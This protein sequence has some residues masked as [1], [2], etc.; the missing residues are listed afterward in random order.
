M[1]LYYLILG[2]I[3]ILGFG[4]IQG[5][6]INT[7]ERKAINEDSKAQ[8]ELAAHYYKIDNN[9]E[10]SKKALRWFN[11]AAQNGESAAQHH[12]GLM[13]YDGR[14]TT[15]N[16][17]EAYKWFLIAASNNQF[18]AKKWAN[19]TEPHL[20]SEQI[21]NVQKIARNWPKSPDT[22]N[23][24][25]DF[26]NINRIKLNPKEIYENSSKAVV[27]IKSFDKEDKPIATRNIMR[28]KICSFSHFL[29]A[30]SFTM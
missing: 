15:K 5:E 23:T 21:F 7:L 3:Y 18:G 13:Y 30:V 6:E 12:L 27:F 4:L 16:Y 17:L 28:A 9:D 19:K 24:D 25:S 22:S 14:G 29:Q 8:L 2:Q 26:Q 20:S 10:S 1:K 11:R